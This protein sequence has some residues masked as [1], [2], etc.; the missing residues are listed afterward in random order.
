MFLWTINKLK[1]MHIGEVVIRRQ[2]VNKAKR[3]DKT[4]EKVEMKRD[5]ISK[6]H[7]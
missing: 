3:G 4:D 6:V 5:L 1:K 2:E 7:M